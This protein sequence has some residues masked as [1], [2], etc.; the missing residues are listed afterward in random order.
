[1]NCS[2]SAHCLY[3]TKGAAD[4]AL[5]ITANHLPLTHIRV[6]HFATMTKVFTQEHVQQFASLVGDFNPAHFD[7]QYVQQEMKG[8]FKGK[9]VHGIL[10]G[11]LIS[12]LAGTVLPGPGSIYLSQNFRFVKPA[13]TNDLLCARVECKK[14]LNKSGNVF[15]FETTVTNQTTGEV[16][17]NGEA[18]VYHPKLRL[19]Q[20]NSK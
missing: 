12:A 9:V 17:I 7:D 14:A 15:L 13:Y 20:E 4:H 18:T 5:Q 3:S 1:M 10:V 19:L 2:T 11:G 6:G 8:I 16:L